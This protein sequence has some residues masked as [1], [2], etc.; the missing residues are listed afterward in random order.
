E[1]E[2]RSLL[3]RFLDACNA[4]AYAHSRGVLHRDI[5]PANIML[6]PYGETLVVDWGVAKII[7]SASSPSVT[8]EESPFP[9]APAGTLAPTRSGS[10]V[11]TPAFMSPEQAAGRLDKLTPASDVYSLGAT[12]YTLL[13]GRLPFEGDT[14]AILREVQRGEVLPPRKVAGTVPPALEA[15][16]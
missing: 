15:T 6:G 8:E 12:L 1:L 11:G 16:C 13:T 5:K 4:I 3:D 2:L 7:G 14:E 10:A 9:L